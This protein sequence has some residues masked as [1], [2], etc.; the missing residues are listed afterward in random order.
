MSGS[1]ARRSREARLAVLLTV[2][3]LVSV[4]AGVP[5]P[6]SPSASDDGGEATA[7]T[8]GGAET[9]AVQ[10]IET[11]TVI[12]TPGRYELVADVTQ[13]EGPACIVIAA[14]DV[15]LDG[16][17]YTVDTSFEGDA[18]AVVGEDVS[19][20]TVE[21]LVIDNVQEGI[22]VDVGATSSVGDLTVRNNEIDSRSRAINLTLSGSN[23]AV[24][25]DGVTLANNVLE[26]G[27]EG[28]AVEMIDETGW[29]A[30]NLSIRGNDVRSG[31][32][33]VHVET[34]GD[35]MTV[36]N[37]EFRNNVV[38]SGDH[39][40][41]LIADGTG[42]AVTG[43]SVVGND[44]R[45]EIGYRSGNPIRIL[46]NDPNQEL[47]VTVADN[48]LNAT[49]T[50]GANEGIFVWADG[51]GT[52]ASVGV[53]NNTVGA[54]TG[55]S[56]PDN[57]IKFTVDGEDQVLDTAVR[58][59]T[60]TATDDGIELDA[61]SF[62]DASTLRATIADNEVTAGV[63]G[64]QVE[65]DGSDNDAQVSVR[66]N[67]LEV[68]TDGIEV[69]ADDS[70][71]A[72]TAT[73]ANNVVDGAAAD[74][75][76][77]D[78]GGDGAT[79]DA[80][81]D[82][83]VVGNGDTGVDL[84]LAG[85]NDR[86]DVS[87]LDNELTVEGVAVVTAGPVDGVVLDGNLLDGGLYGVRNDNTTSGYV[88]ATNNDWGSPDGPDSAGPYADPVTGTLAD[89]N[90]SN[91][92][93]LSGGVSNVRFDPWTG[94]EE[95]PGGAE[96]IDGCTV[97]DE[98]GRYELTGNVTAESAE[99]CIRI[100]ASNVTFDG[101]GYT[102]DGVNG[103]SGTV[104]ILVGARA[105]TSL[106][107][108][109]AETA[110]G[111]ENVTVRT[112]R[113]V[114]W[115]AGIRLASRI[116]PTDD[117]A[118]DGVSVVGADSGIVVDR[119]RG[120]TIRDSV[121][122]DASVYGI[123]LR[124]TTGATVR[125][126]R[127]RNSSFGVDVSFSA[128]G[129]VLRDN[130]VG[131]SDRTGI[132]VGGPDTVVRNNTVRDGE[133][134]VLLL[135]SDVE[136]A[137]VAENTV[138]GNLVGIQIGPFA[139]ASSFRNNVV[140]GNAVGVLLEGAQNHTF[141]GTAFDGNGGWSVQA[142]PST[143][144]VP[145]SASNN[146][147]TDVTFATTGGTFTFTL[148]DTEIRPAVEVPPLPDGT[149][150]VGVFVRA[151]N[152]SEAGRLD[153]EVTYD[154]A[155]A[156][157]VNEETLSVWRYDGEWT[158]RGGSVDPTENT[159]S[160]T[161]ESFS[162]FAVLGDPASET[163]ADVVVEGTNAPVTEGETLVVEAVLRNTGDA[164]VEER[165]SLVVGGVERDATTVAVEPG[166]IRTVRL[167]W[168]TDSGDAGT[169]AAAVR[170]E[171]N[172]D[173]A[174]VTVEQ[175]SEPPPEQIPVFSVLVD[176]TNS[177]V[178]AGERVDVVATVRNTGDAE[179]TESVTLS[180][181]GTVVDEVGVTVPPGET[182]RVVLTWDTD[183]GDV[184]EQV[185]VVTVGD[186]SDATIVRVESTNRPPVAGFTYS[187][188]VPSPGEEVT[189]E[190]TPSD[191]DGTVEGYE[192]RIDGEVVSTEPAFEWRFDREGDRNVS[193][194]VTDDDGSTNGT[195]RTVEVAVLTV[196][197]WTTPATPVTGE[198]VSLVATTSLDDPS[199][200]EYR[201]TVDGEEQFVTPSPY[202]DVVFDE[203][204]HHEVTVEVVA[205]S[206]ETETDAVGVVVEE[207]TRDDPT[208]TPPPTTTEPPPTA[209]P[210]AGTTTAGPPATTTAPETT[211]PP[212]DRTTA[213]GTGTT[214][215]GPGTTRSETTR[216]PEETTAPDA[217]PT[218][219]PD[220]E[221]TSGDGTDEGETT[222][223]EPGD[224]TATTEPSDGTERSSP[225]GTSDTADA[226]DG[227]PNGTAPATDG[228]GSPGLG[229]GAALVALGC[230]LVLRRR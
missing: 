127:L 61:G 46:A 142:S 68:E 174:E 114:D 8:A 44:V 33:G 214:T 106:G 199:E 13:P 4:V 223:A 10:P 189:F 88:D 11:C 129:T 177:P 209:D 181:G 108:A 15:R 193:L 101:N 222:G 186:A 159:V 154:D 53:T 228:D 96:P 23:T 63:L 117:V 39:G 130:V 104:G 211:T 66:R 105:E 81:V 35:D 38:D 121:V 151:R 149:A 169:Y 136:N 76:A 118:V 200:A 60:V 119:G 16:A 197:L 124:E 133:S 59:N 75:V 128:T 51:D 20:V 132:R 24:T 210:P 184:G 170:G 115:A 153:L 198:S 204:G 72:L 212:D 3:V 221:T 9:T 111:L 160:K 94:K 134:A 67:R 1:A 152:T 40:I 216:G 57:G 163:T 89:G 140:R 195:N 37:Y 144:E 21:N 26:S 116:G 30:R 187:P 45:S 58:N 97:I 179:G 49:N 194:V 220:R 176:E 2:L 99:Y 92:T 226:G 102:V 120:V 28:I 91:V 18:V 213:P 87:L 86:V 123:S 54:L 205:P 146:T 165:V 217:P 147:F 182:A 171:G 25:V 229:V 7:S 166:E 32:V 190:A 90:G 107:W 69:E 150:D 103:E 43:V 201:W 95:S 14:S 207:R 192:W 56:P 73:I 172:A 29:A 137:T 110:Q 162:V 145:Q 202:A 65:A 188:R 148:T 208:T 185:P 79:V 131:E 206:E 219:D 100:T 22:R 191:P 122:R 5:V 113:V 84:R 227:T 48:R 109:P 34:Y 71:V 83:N 157:D 141:E 55:Q 85:G 173:E 225:G 6:A 196:D 74:G 19:N 52:E 180:V 41:Q 64:I 167:S 31:G 77:L 93:E 230:L 218:T 139:G 156:S 42:E 36:Q 138:A 80:T 215:P 178:D 47:G 155:A 17:G 161:V 175:R 82:G 224:P 135:G 203:A 70:G 12:E 126:N 183:E 168:E 143:G 62:S 50:S 125:N 164:T 158:D 98:P 112:V 78:A 27:D